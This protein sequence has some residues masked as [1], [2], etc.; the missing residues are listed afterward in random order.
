M[1]TN[2]PRP[3]LTRAGVSFAYPMKAGAKINQGAL[4]ALE[5]GLLVPGKTGAGLVAIGVART[6]VDNSAGADGALGA[7]PKP[8][9]SG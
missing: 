2:A 8:A 1:A 5:G 6:S 4:V 9:V 7:S 3:T